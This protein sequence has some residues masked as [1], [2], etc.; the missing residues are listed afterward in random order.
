MRLT[1]TAPAPALPVTLGEFSSHLRLAYGFPDD[2]AE[3]ALL[4]L[5]LR[6]ATAAIE[7]RLGR[8]LI[9]RGFRLEVGS[10]DRS[11]HLVLPVGP[12]ES[13]T[14]FRFLGPAGAVDVAAASFALEPGTARQRVTGPGGAALPPIPAGHVAELTFEA[15]YGP[16]G[17]DVPG[18]L[19]QAVLLLA[20]HFYENRRGEAAAEGG[21]PGA[22]EAIIRAERPLRL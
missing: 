11:G 9:R 8:A 5:Y 2:G 22:V 17:S 15:G 13:I 6:N 18:E 10:W 19:R 7:A 16:A 12:V 21:L 3:D 20:A 14:S 4:D 1:E